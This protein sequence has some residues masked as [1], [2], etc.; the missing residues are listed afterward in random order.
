MGEG[1]ICLPFF[2]NKHSPPPWGAG[3]ERMGGTWAHTGIRPKGALGGRGAGARP[4]RGRPPRAGSAAAEAV[5]LRRAAAWRGCRATCAMG[6]GAQ[7]WLGFHGWR[8]FLWYR[9]LEILKKMGGPW[10]R[11]FFA[12]L[13]QGH[14]PHRVDMAD[15]TSGLERLW[16]RTPAG[17]IGD[18][19]QGATHLV[20]SFRGFPLT[21]GGCAAAAE[22]L[23]I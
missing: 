17:S 9:N 23:Q 19:A 15:E 8:R 10:E 5:S 22:Q 16:T 12:L 21:P 2:E 6:G 4:A 14:P 11:G 3:V 20:P 7:S 13:K 1:C 18:G